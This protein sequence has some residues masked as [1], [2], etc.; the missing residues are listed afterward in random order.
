[1]S[2]DGS[3]FPCPFDIPDAALW[4][5]CVLI[6]ILVGC[7]TAEQSPR[8]SGGK[9]TVLQQRCDRLIVELPNHMIVIV[10][11]LPTTSVVSAQVWVKTGSIYEQEHVGAGLSH[12]LE[13]L[14]SGGS[15]SN[16]TESESNANLGRIGAQTNAATSLDTVQYFINTTSPNGGVA[17]DLL[18][19]WLSSSL[20]PVEEYEREREVIQR[21][22]EMG[23]GEPGRIFWKLTQQARYRAHPARH[24]TIGYLD[25]FLTISR[26]E[27][28]D[29]YRRMYVPN[30]MVFSVAGDVDKQNVVE[31]IAARWLNVPSGPL[32]QLSFPQEPQIDRPRTIEGRA[33]IERPRLR[34]AWP[35]TQLAGEGDYALDLLAVVL[36]QGESSRLVRTVRDDQRLV[37]TIGAYNLSFSWGRGFFGVDAKVDVP[38]IPPN[39]HATPQ[40]WI[41]QCIDRTEAEILAQI[42]PLQEK[43]VT[44]TELARSKRKVMASVVQSN[45]TA[46]EVAARLARDVIGMADPDYLTKY[47]HAVQNLT[48]QDLQAAAQKYLSPDRLITIRLLPQAEGPPPLALRRPETPAQ[49]PQFERQRVQIENAQLVTRLQGNLASAVSPSRRIEV[50]PLVSYELDNGLRLLVQRSTVVPAVAMQMYWFGGLLGEEPGR[51]GLAN[52]AAKMMMRGTTTHSAEAIAEAIDD[53]GAGLAVSC[54]NNTTYAQA[55]ALAEDWPRVLELMAD[56]VLRPSWP[57]DQWRKMQPRLLAAIDQQRD[58]WWGELSAHFRL[59]YYGEHPWSQTPLGRKDVVAALTVGDL[60]AYHAARLAAENTVMAVVGDVDPEQ[61][62]RQVERYFGGL[63]RLAELDF[64]PPLPAAPASRIIQRQTAKPVTAVQL[65]F[66]PGIDRA[67]PDYATMLV[68]SRLMSDFPAGWLERQLRGKDEGLAYVVSAWSQAGLV[69]GH[70]TILFNTSASAAPEALG[71]ALSVVERAKHGTIEQTDLER[72]KSKV[73]TAEILGKQSTASRAAEAALD[74][75]YGVPD[76]GASRFMGQVEAVSAEAVQAVASKYLRNPVVVVLGHEPVDAQALEKA[77]S[78]PDR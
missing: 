49:A 34:L 43:P 30:N 52:A 5:V 74:E 68:L 48:A 72:A 53:L 31:Q 38:P 1:M 45:Q 11:E 3:R 33:D 13:H 25:E 73:I 36:G 15:T 23:Q 9:Y 14:I 56:V 37:N 58:R 29:F 63:P 76:P 39:V 66:G 70:F 42:R 17:I 21:E 67:S 10:Q 16:R 44:E 24:P 64:D 61:V 32:P 22:F 55:T 40:Q 7:R 75:L 4:A 35:G 60:R 51:E 6:T 2:N 19:D 69:P 78:E 27:I 65:G 8:S 71:R 18:S 54:G 26:D 62:R 57:E 47:A 12:F 59:A 28:Y 41:D 77:I 20:V 50:D 46:Q